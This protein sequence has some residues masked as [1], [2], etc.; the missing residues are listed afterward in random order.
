MTDDFCP[1]FVYAI[2][3]LKYSSTPIPD[4][5]IWRKGKKIDFNLT[6]KILK[7]LVAL[8]WDI[9]QIQQTSSL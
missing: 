1:N 4:E 6:M 2:G 7:T 8:K 5:I 3:H 9:L